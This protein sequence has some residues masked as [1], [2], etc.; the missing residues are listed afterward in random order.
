[1][2]RLRVSLLIPAPTRTLRESRLSSDVTLA[3]VRFFI[4]EAALSRTNRSVFNPGGFNA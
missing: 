3:K 2:S 4:F 1:M